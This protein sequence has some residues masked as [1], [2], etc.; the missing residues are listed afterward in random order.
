MNASPFSKLFPRAALLATGASLTFIIHFSALSGDEPSPA[1]NHSDKSSHNQLLKSAVLAAIE[2][3]CEVTY[4][5]EGQTTTLECPSP[6]NPQNGIRFV[7]GEE[8]NLMV[9]RHDS[10]RLVRIYNDE[11]VLVDS[12]PMPRETKS[13]F[14]DRLTARVIA[15]KADLAFRNKDTLGVALQ[16]GRATYM[17]GASDVNIRPLE[18]NAGHYVAPHRSTIKISPLEV[19]GRYTEPYRGVIKINA[20]EIIEPKNQ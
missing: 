16:D 17:H 18:V 5:Q 3:G 10:A 8:E 13:G 4:K 12:Y 2:T 14:F 19:A 6:A 7:L 20:L 11:K 1:Q 9:I 15:F